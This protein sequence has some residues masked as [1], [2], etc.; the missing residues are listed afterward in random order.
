VTEVILKSFP[1]LQPNDNQFSQKHLLANFNQTGL[2]KVY[3][4]SKPY[5]ELLNLVSK[6]N[7][8]GS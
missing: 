5:L 7:D 8:E 6:M 3:Q 2:F 1:I 4:Q